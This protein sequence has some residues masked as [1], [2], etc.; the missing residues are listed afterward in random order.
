MFFVLILFQNK[1]S[2]IKYV[3]SNLLHFTPCPALRHT[4][5]NKRM[6]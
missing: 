1:G 3:R 6:V 4:L 2:A 5:F